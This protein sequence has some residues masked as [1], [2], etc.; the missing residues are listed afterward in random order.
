M[1]K[2]LKL[3]LHP[4]KVSIKTFGSGVDFLGW[5]NFSNYKVLR[6]TAKRKMFRRLAESQKEETLASYLGMLNHGNGFKLKEKI[7]TMLQ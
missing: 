3:F 5:V 2:E 7:I 6:T 1:N 4:N